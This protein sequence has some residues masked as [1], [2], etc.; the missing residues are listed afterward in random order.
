M[1][2]G[3]LVEAFDWDSD[4]CPEL[5]IGTDAE[6]VI[7]T[8]RGGRTQRYV[9]A[10]TLSFDGVEDVDSDGRPDLVDRHRFTRERPDCLRT[11]QVRIG[12]PTVVLHSAT[13]GTFVESDEVTR[14]HLLRQCPKPPK[15][16][17]V[18]QAGTLDPHRSL[19]NIACARLWG[20]TGEQVEARIL[21]E[22]PKWQDDY[23]AQSARNLPCFWRY[24]L[25]RQADIEPPLALY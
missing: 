2:E 21:R 5:V 16:L 6:L 25:V 7:W 19:Q 4:G 10:E 8:Y 1:P 13:D 20:A 14:A 12:G 3:K 11:N 18:G 22:W 24:D 15:Q 9:P 17:L 23:H